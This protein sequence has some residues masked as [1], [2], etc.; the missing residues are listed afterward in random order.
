MDIFS[1]VKR[2][3]SDLLR[4]ANKQKQLVVDQFKKF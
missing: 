3:P 1:M 2:F 4:E